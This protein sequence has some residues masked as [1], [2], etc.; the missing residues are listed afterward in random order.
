MYCVA[1]PLALC[2]SCTRSI[3]CVAIIPFCNSVSSFEFPVSR[4]PTPAA[5]NTKLETRNL[6]LALTFSHDLSK[7]GDGRKFRDQPVKQRQPH[8]AQTFIFDHHHDLIE[9]FI[10]GRP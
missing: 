5:R 9:K 10:D 7:I 3:V 6:K 1:A 8:A 2:F 4:I